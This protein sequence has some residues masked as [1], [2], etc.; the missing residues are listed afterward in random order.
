MLTTY[1]QQLL[2]LADARRVDLRDAFLEAGLPDS[3]YYRI[4]QRP[5]FTM[6]FDVAQKVAEL[7][8]EIPEAP[9]QPGH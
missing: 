8:A 3:T 1:Y 7:L 2:A 4:L 9:A 6:S 5:N